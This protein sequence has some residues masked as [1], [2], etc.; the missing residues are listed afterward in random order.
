M[1]KLFANS[2]HPDQILQNGASDLGLHCLPFLG[3]SRLKCVKGKNLLPEQP[4]RVV[5]CKK[6]SSGMC[7]QQRLKIILWSMIRTA[8]LTLPIDSHVADQGP[9]VQ[10]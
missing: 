4:L 2:R 1:A 9:V 5:T 10:S 8:L 6:K 7:R 3:A